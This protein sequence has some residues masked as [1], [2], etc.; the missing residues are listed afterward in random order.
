MPNT[1]AKCHLLLAAISTPDGRNCGF[2]LFLTKQ[3]VIAKIS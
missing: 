1:I 2:N 3:I